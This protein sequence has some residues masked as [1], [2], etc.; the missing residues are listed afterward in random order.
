MRI[1]GIIGWSG[2]GKTTLLTAVLPILQSCGMTVNVVKHSHHDVML[3]PESKDSARFRAAGAQEVMLVSP[4]RYAIMHETPAQEPPLES[5]LARLAPA[6]LTLI[7]GYKDS[8]YPKIEVYRPAVGKPPKY[9]DDAGVIAVAT[10]SVLETDLPLLDLNAPEAIAN[11]VQ[12][13]VESR[14]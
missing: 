10:D 6:D 9:V 7:E 2:S 5:L 1:L 13:W 12:D 11:W 4:Y 3:E 14:S 8:H